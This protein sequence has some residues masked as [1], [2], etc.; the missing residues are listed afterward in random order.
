MITLAITPGT[1]LFAYLIL[2]AVGL[3]AF[4]S[5]LARNSNDSSTTAQCHF[6]HFKLQSEIRHCPTTA[7][8]SVLEKKVEDFRHDFQ[9]KVDR[10]LLK[11]FVADLH[12]MIATRRSLLRLS[13]TSFSTV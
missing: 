8:L 2:I 12:A 11:D 7:Q 3:L 1:V 10:K 6:R 13:G 5:L 4:L 9:G